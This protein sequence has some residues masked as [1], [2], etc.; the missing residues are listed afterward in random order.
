MNTFVIVATIVGLFESAFVEAF[1]K[2]GEN[3]ENGVEISRLLTI[4]NE[5]GGDLHNLHKLATGRKQQR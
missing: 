5:S 4:N 3:G 1:S 2:E